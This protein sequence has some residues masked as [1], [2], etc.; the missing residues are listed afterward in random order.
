MKISLKRFCFAIS[1]AFVL[2]LCFAVQP[3]NYALAYNNADEAQA[4]INDLNNQAQSVQTQIDDANARLEQAQASFEEAIQKMDDFTVEYQSIIKT[5][6][7][8][9]PDVI[10]IPDKSFA[11]AFALAT[12]QTNSPQVFP[13]KYIFKTL[14]KQVL[15]DED[16]PGIDVYVNYYLKVC[17]VYDRY[18]TLYN[19]CIDDLGKIDSEIINLKALYSQTNSQI[20]SSQSELQRLQQLQEKYSKQGASLIVGFGVFCHPCP[21]Y[22][23]ISTLFGANRGSYNHKGIDFAAPY[24]TPIY[25]ASDGVVTEAVNNGGYNSGMGNYVV[26]KHNNGLVTKYYHC[27]NL[28][29]S[30]GQS[31]TKGQHIAA[32]GSTGDSTGNHLHFQVELNG[33]PVD[34]APL[35]GM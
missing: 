11:A 26:I 31:V 33:N 13:N 23:Q 32:V 25:A 14:M 7:N 16:A 15:F 30:V 29:V 10:N 21:G 28:F 19:Q 27:S 22:K 1:A 35:I 20:S 18:Q 12:V 24:A 4:G 2:V 3:H 9:N 6:Q 8:I 5:V 34:P 17:N